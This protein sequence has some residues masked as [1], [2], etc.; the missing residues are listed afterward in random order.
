MQPN[1]DPKFLARSQVQVILNQAPK[2]T[3]PAG[4][5]QG[6]VSKGYK[7]EGF[8][9]KPAPTPTAEPNLAER[10]TTDIK[11]RGA[12][13]DEA[14]SGTGEYQDKSLLNRGLGATKE[15]LG[16]IP[17]VAIDVLPSPVRNLIGKIGDLTGKGFHYIADK[18]G[19]TQLFK[20]AVASGDTK[21]LE[22]ALGSIASGGDIA[23][24]ILATEGGAKSLEKGKN[25]IKTGV[26]N[27]KNAFTDVIENTKQSHAVDTHNSTLQKTVDMTG[28]ILN[29][30]ERINAIKEGRGNSPTNFNKGSIQASDLDIKRAN[31]INDVI[32][33]DDLNTNISDAKSAIKHIS[34]NVVKPFLEENPNHYDPADL[35]AYVE[36][37]VQPTMSIKSNPSALKIF[38]DI[39]DKALNIASKM[40]NDTG[41]ILE[42]RKV[43]D[44]F[45]KKEYGDTV[46]QEAQ[47]TAIKQAP[48]MA[49]NAFNDFVADSLKFKGNIGAVNKIE[50][51]LAE[52]QKR[53]IKLDSLG[54]AREILQKQFG[55]EPLPEDAFKEAFFR[56]NMK[57]MS[58]LYEAVDN[59]AQRAE[60]TINDSKVSAKIKDFKK[61]NPLKTKAANAAVR[62]SVV[63]GL[64]N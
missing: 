27:T 35:E 41:G 23:N 28:D 10:V 33:S 37:K 15:A 38:N 21:G 50:D 26:E 43:L 17:A 62:A 56:Y 4:I 24:S 22:D 12:K 40:P 39:K 2:G 61:N 64:I 52:T 47:N 34:E 55:A 8:N 42:A 7:L 31:L 36:R 30:D 16:A 29:K 20:D 13:V 6:L 18:L 49:R 9:D 19:D 53:G 45:I 3:T 32:K 59:M 60:S 5:I 58:A 25:L 11:D 14:I 46:F 57:K 63:G 54:D 44:S 48:V 1:T 51:I